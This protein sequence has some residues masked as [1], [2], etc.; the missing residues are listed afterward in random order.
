MKVVGQYLIAV[1]S[2]KYILSED[3]KANYLNLIL[4]MDKSDAIEYV[5]KSI[6][7]VS[8][9]LLQNKEALNI[10]MIEGRNPDLTKQETDSLDEQFSSLYIKDRKLKKKYHCLK[11]LQNHIAE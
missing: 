1:D 2:E 8:A 4:Y 9:E 7:E 10:N 6:E 11:W 5:N 3:E